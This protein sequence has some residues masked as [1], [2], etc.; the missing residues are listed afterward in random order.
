MTHFF[1]NYLTAVGTMALVAWARYHLIGRNKRARTLNVILVSF[2]FLLIA[3][4]GRQRRR[5]SLSV[6][7]TFKWP[8]FDFISTNGMLRSSKIRT[9]PMT[10]SSLTADWIYSTVNGSFWLPRAP[11][12]NRIISG[13]E[14]R[15][16]GNKFHTDLY[17]GQSG[18]MHPDKID[19]IM[20][21]STG[22]NAGDFYALWIAPMV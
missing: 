5:S 3:R 14:S 10:D 1:D 8:Q 22:F 12:S 7:P 19:I 4:L 21:Q 16:E 13:F 11:P 20:A 15:M 9:L 2:S 6:S 18:F 17:K